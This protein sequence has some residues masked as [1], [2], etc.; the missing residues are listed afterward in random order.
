MTQITD[1]TAKSRFELDINGAIAF[2]NYRIEDT[3]LYIDYVEAPIALRGTGAASQLMAWV[4]ETANAQ[5]LK[6]II[7]ERRIVDRARQYHGPHQG[8]QD[9][10][11]LIALIGRGERLQGVEIVTQ[12]FGKHMLHSLWLARHIGG[13]R[14]K[15]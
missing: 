3:T 1:N 14:R 10:D 13:K 11:S 15:Q 5:Q 9:T 12:P 2:A 8:R 4:M 7:G 6:D